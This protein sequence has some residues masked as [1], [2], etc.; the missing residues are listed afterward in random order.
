MGKVK[1]YYQLKLQ[2][3]K[4]KTEK[5]EIRKELISE[6]KKLPGKNEDKFLMEDNLKA[7]ITYKRSTVYDNPTETKKYFEKLGLGELVN[8]EIKFDN[9]KID[10]LIKKGKLNKKEIDKMRTVS[11]TSPTLF[12]DVV[13]KG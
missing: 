1:K 9:K 4:I 2:E 12:V 8:V 11:W 13:E 3:D 6:I 5:N 10:E 7:E